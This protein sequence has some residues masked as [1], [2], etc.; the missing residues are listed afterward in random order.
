MHYVE[1]AP[2][3]DQPQRFGN[4]AYRKWSDLVRDVSGEGKK[5]RGGRKGREGGWEGREGEGREG[6][7]AER[8]EERRKQ[9][10]GKL[11]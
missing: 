11:G 10:T 3:L 2:P 8:K 4:K 6:G 1:E 5:G 7:S 9:G